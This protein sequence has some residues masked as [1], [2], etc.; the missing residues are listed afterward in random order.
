MLSFGD[1]ALRKNYIC[2]KKKGARRW[3]GESAMLS[4]VI[5]HYG[6]MC[7]VTVRGDAIGGEKR[8]VK[9]CWGCFFRLFKSLRYHTGKTL[10]EK[11]QLMLLI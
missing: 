7:N 8:N 5:L 9:N 2:E 6:K 10:H 4:L 11:T 1:A 3:Q